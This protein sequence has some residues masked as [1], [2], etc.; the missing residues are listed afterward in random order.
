MGVTPTWHQAES[1]APGQSHPLLPALQNLPL[2][3]GYHD[4][5]PRELPE[6][7]KCTRNPLCSR[8]TFQTLAVGR[9]TQI[10]EENL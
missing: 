5:S 7:Q 8:V 6:Y 9:R 4:S 2:D 1:M 10:P 3:A